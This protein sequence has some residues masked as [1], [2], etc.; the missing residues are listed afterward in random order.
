M[1]RT[2][3]AENFGGEVAVSGRLLIFDEE[4]HGVR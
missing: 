2:S 3:S 1:E 4:L